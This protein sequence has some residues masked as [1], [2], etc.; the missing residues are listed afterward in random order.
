[1][2][3]SVVLAQHARKYWYLQHSG[4]HRSI[5]Q[6]MWE[7]FFFFFPDSDTKSNR[8]LPFW[9]VLESLKRQP[10]ALLIEE[11]VEERPL[12]TDFLSS[13]H[14]R[15]HALQSAAFPFKPSWAGSTGRSADAWNIRRSSPMSQIQ[16][17]VRTG[18]KS[19]NSGTATDCG[20]LHDVKGSSTSLI[21]PRS[22]FHGAYLRCGHTASS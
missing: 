10:T 21:D 6:L 22:Q 20:V 14:C 3:R 19:S 15:C 9:A 12:G 16:A 18:G 1:M 5:R 2:R 7:V 8:C 17:L 11:L 13:H 4:Q